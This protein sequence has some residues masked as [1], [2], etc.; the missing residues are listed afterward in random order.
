MKVGDTAFIVESNRAIREVIIVKC[1]G[2]LYLVKFKDTG[3][4]IQVK[5]HRLFPTE[6]EARQSIMVHTKPTKR[7]TPYDYM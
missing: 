2:G 6:D 3:G 1:A 7:K 4:G 5:K